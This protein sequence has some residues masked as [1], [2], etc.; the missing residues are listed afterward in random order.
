MITC[1]Q[2]ISSFSSAMIFGAIFFRLKRGQSGVQ[3]R[4]GLLQVCDHPT[5]I[6]RSLAAEDG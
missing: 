5:V 2:A 6:Y 1:F 4:L 3:D